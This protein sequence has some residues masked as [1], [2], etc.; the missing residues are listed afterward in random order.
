MK[1]VL[2][3]SAYFE[4]PM[5]QTLAVMEALLASVVYCLDNKSQ[6]KKVIIIN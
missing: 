6:S 4:A 2:N 5:A 1:C 3:C